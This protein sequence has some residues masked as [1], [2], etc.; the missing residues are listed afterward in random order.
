MCHAAGIWTLPRSDANIFIGW[1]SRHRVKKNIG[2]LVSAIEAAEA[3]GASYYIASHENTLGKPFIN[4]NSGLYPKSRRVRYLRSALGD[5]PLRVVYYIREQAGLLESYYLQTIHE[6]GRCSFRDFMSHI[7]IDN[8]SWKPVYETLCANFGVENVVVKSFE[9][10]I[11]KGQSAYLEN[12]LRSS[13]EDDLSPFGKFKYHPVRNPSIGWLGLR[14]SLFLNAFASAP[15]K[16]RQVRNFMQKHFSNRRFARPRLLT[17]DE[18]YILSVLYGEENREIVE[19]S[20]SAV[21]KIR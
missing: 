3:E 7:D 9:E 21:E 1:G 12:F 5:R 19:R 14:L 13:V 16:R 15:E 17:E 8:I 2:G 20:A 18:K 4:N 10:E 6:G 11:A